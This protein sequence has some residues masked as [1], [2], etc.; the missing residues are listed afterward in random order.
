MR[1][2]ERKRIPRRRRQRKKKGKKGEKGT[3]LARVSRNISTI[4]ATPRRIIVPSSPIPSFRDPVFGQTCRISL[5]AHPS[6]LLPREIRVILF[7]P[8]RETKF[9]QQFSVRAAPEGYSRKSHLFPRNVHFSDF[10]EPVVL[11]FDESLNRTAIEFPVK[12]SRD[13]KILVV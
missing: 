3:E 11:I 1:T 7:R 10:R 4:G 13:Q 2:R 12:I 8:A 5:G 6:R 9:P